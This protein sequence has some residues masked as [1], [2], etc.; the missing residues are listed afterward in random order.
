LIDLCA[1]AIA[2]AKWRTK[3]GF[4]IVVIVTAGG[5]SDA[6]LLFIHAGIFVHARVACEND[7]EGCQYG[8]ERSQQIKGS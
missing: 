2:D 3:I 1:A 5:E 4:M 8:A 7:E 6:S